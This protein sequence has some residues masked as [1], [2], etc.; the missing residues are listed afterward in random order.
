MDRAGGPRWVAEGHKLG[1]GQA[2]AVGEAHGEEGGSSMELA[3]LASGA[4][5]FS[6]IHAIQYSRLAGWLVGLPAQALTRL[7]QRARRP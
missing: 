1:H 5:L 3:L 6:A 2:G 7:A 4:V